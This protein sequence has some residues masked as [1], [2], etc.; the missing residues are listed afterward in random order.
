MSTSAPL[1]S[2]DVTTAYDETPYPS[3]SFPQTQP[4]RLAAMARLFGLDAASPANARVLELGCADGSNLLPLA[5]QFPQASFLG[6]DSSKVQIA[7]AQSAITAGGV[8]NVEVRRQDILDFPADS[9][10]FDYI[11]AHGVYSWVPPAVREKVLAICR[12]HLTENGVAYVSYNALPGWNMRR[13]LREMMLYHTRGLTDPKTKVAQSRALLTFLADSVPSENSAYG[14]LL[15]SELS[16]M[17][18]LSDNYLLHDILGGENTPF[19]F[20]EFIAEA[21]KHGLQ[22]LSES[23]I[24]EMLAGN[25]PEKVSQTLAQLNNQIVAQEQYMDYLRNRSFRQTLLCRG[26]VPLKRNLSPAVLRQLAFRSL[27]IRAAGPVELVPGVPVSFATATGV[28][29]TSGDAFVKALMQMLTETRGVAVVSYQALL[30]GARSLSRPFLGE[31]PPDRDRTDESTLE[32]N[33]LNLLAKGFLEIHAEPVSVRTDVPERPAVSAFARYQALNARLITN[34]THQSIPADMV[35]RYI[36]A[37]CDGTRGRD[38]LLGE[39]VSRVKEGKLQ[40]NEGSVQVT[41]EQ[42]LNALLG[43]NLD[44]GLAALA[45]AGFFRG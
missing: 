14:M 31:V 23:N 34:R 41:D 35:A 9:G 27:L 1:P 28:Q 37:A 39:L 22:Y 15:K 42:R 43:S 33:L 3:S 45:A 8:T 44:T 17:N 16:L 10:K 11:V 18:G 19:Y 7:A 21:M 6:V 29:V 13:S 20:Y 5:E 12:D 24:A 32:M 26:G 2:S 25:F 30:E 40:V 4:N 36:I 38:E